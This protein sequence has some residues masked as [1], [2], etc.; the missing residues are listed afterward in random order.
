MG[1]G[2]RH[3]CIRHAFFLELNPYHVEIGCTKRSLHWGFNVQALGGN[4]TKVYGHFLVV[5]I[6]I[7][8]LLAQSTGSRREP[9]NTAAQTEV[10]VSQQTSRI[11]PNLVPDAGQ[12]PI[13]NILTV[14]GD[15]ILGLPCLDCVLSLLFPTLGLPSPQGRVF[16]G[17]AYQ[18]D[19]FLIDN[20]YTG[21][22]TFTFAVRDNQKNVIVSTTQTLMEN[23]GT[24]IL[25][26]APVTI[27]VNASVGLGSVSTTATCGTSTTRSASPV[28]VSACVTNPPFC[29][30]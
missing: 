11:T 27:P 3:S 25:I 22:C 23:A 29:T 12:P 28:V 19:S 5:A 1:G 15:N 18:I 20:R 6:P 7:T 2:R 8:S 4:M 13:L 30:N 24:R 17:N 16:Q 14:M 9:G 26:T 10:K 21:S